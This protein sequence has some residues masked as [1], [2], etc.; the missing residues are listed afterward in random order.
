[1]K[2]TQQDAGYTHAHTQPISASAV[3]FYVYIF[4]IYKVKL[5][6]IEYV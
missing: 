2:R 4:F 3:Y 1:M 6:K 5:F